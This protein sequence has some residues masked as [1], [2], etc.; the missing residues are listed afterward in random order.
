MNI[1]EKLKKHKKEI[2]L[3]NSGDLKLNDAFG[4]PNRLIS[5]ITET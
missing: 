4:T 2:K 5:V 3:Y 1:L